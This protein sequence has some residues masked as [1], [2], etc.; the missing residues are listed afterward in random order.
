MELYR[1]ISLTLNTSRILII[2]WFIELLSLH[3]SL[4]VF[5]F[6]EC[7]IC[8][9]LYFPE[10]Q[11]KDNPAFSMLNDSDDDVIYGSDYEEMPLQNGQAIRAK[12]K[13]ESD[14]D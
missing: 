8:H 13:E 10:S 2:L 9:C 14:S 11:L 3:I 1:A 4:R 7:T 12:Y 5:P 6:K